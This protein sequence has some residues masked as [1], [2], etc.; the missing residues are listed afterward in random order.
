MTK[1]FS[2]SLDEDL[3]QLVEKK[4]HEKRQSRSQFIKECILKNITIEEAND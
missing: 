3:W 4:R 2:I 1:K